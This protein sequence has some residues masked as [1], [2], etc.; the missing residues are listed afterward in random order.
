MAEHVPDAVIISNSQDSYLCIKVQVSS[1]TY[2]YQGECW[3]VR[4]FGGSYGLTT[5]CKES[6][7]FWFSG[8]ELPWTDFFFSLIT[9]YFLFYIILTFD[10]NFTWEG[11]LKTRFWK[12]SEAKGIFRGLLEHLFLV[13]RIFD[14]F[15][16]M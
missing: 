9:D 14:N 16:Y 1:A 6:T 4:V 5:Y 11:G 13:R 2:Q 3:V 10:F 8:Q 7:W 12:S 15:I